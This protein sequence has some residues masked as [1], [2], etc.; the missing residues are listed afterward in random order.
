M[1]GVVDVARRFRQ[2]VGR[3]GGL[4]TE[5]PLVGAALAQLVD[6]ATGG[7][8]VACTVA[9]H[10]G[11][12]LVD[13]AVRQAHTAHCIERVGRVEAVQVVR[14]LGDAG[15]AERQHR[16]RAIGELAAAGD[17]AWREQRDGFGAAAQRQH[18]QLFGGDDRLGDRVG[19]VDLR[20]VGRRDVHCV[21]VGGAAA[22]G[23]AKGNFRAYADLQQHVV[24]LLDHLPVTLEA[25][26]V[27]AHRQRAQSVAAVRI[28]VG[29]SL[30]AR[31][32]LH[33][34]RGAC[35]GR[36]VAIQGTGGALRRCG[37]DER[38]QD[39]GQCRALQPDG[40]LAIGHE[41]SLFRE[42]TQLRFRLAAS[43]FDHENS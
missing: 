18:V 4:E 39:N 42:K 22:G 10:E 30:E 6:H 11:F 35:G 28:D 15:A 37:A 27:T 3:P 14:V 41:I 33:D 25:D 31:I 19:H 5:L 26:G 9:T 23:L 38:G 17:H 12:L 21:E 20:N 29:A 43:V 13:R 32:A 24:T 2:R 1:I 7:A 36:G 16:A 34:H 8:A 40:R